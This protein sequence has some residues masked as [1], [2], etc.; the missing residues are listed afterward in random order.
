MKLFFDK[1]ARSVVLKKLKNG[2]EEEK[3]EEASADNDGTANT[4][5]TQT[6]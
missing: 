6:E 3:K 2:G 4:I 5:S 1:E